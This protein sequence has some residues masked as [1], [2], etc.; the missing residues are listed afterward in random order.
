MNPRRALFALLWMP[1]NLLAI[2]PFPTALA[3]DAPS[4]IGWRVAALLPADVILLGEQHDIAQHQQIHREAI[5]ALA[6]RRLLGAVALE[7]A[8]RGSSTSG[9]AADAGEAAVQAALRWNEQA[10]PWTSY[11]PAVMAAVRAGVPVLGA[12]LPQA[13]M[14]EA[15]R[16]IKFDMQLP[17]PALKAQQ[18]LIRL[19]HCGMLAEDHITPMTRIQI[20]RDM[21]MAQTL[22]A[23]AAP[24]RVVL[25]LSGA[26][27]ADRT[28]G[29][30]QHLPREL[31]V[32][33]VQLRPIDGTP[34]ELSSA[35]FD[36]VWL[37][38]TAPAKDYCAAF[39][40][41]S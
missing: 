9:L 34:P 20:A 17:G 21:A 33:S 18:Q 31:S 8:E 25:L 11:G 40:R 1:A 13:A 16:D 12:N 36:A 39:K 24:G 38:G 5:E 28:L 35:K 14:G 32:K 2:F 22:G 4:S 30:P 7:M 19:G 37:A 41:T 29:V 27:H 3:Q 10:W 15:M 6:L 23:A 26:G